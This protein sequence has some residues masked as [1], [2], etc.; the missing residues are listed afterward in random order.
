MEALFS[1]DIWIWRWEELCGPGGLKIWSPEQHDLGICFQQLFLQIPVL[2]LMA[3]CSAY[4]CGR[5]SGFVIRGNI[6]KRAIKLRC[7]I[8]LILAF[9]P[10]LQTYID[11]SKGKIPVSVINFF[12]A[13]VQS[14]TWLVHFGYTSVLRKRL[15][16]SPR[17]PVK[18]CVL[19][20][21]YAV[22]IVVSFHSYYLLRLSTE[23]DFSLNLKFNFGITSMVFQFLYALTLLPSEGESEMV[24][25]NSRY[26]QV[27]V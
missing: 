12:F 2:A 3:I 8:V 11:V 5:Q 9:L 7:L 16:L 26:V 4:Y 1:A 10:I 20:S 21:L 27:S 15:G 24:Q 19:W 14:V 13:A 18:I 23:P 22:L 6:Q 17:G 25:Y